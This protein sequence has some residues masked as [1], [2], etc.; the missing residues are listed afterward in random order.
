MSQGYETEIGE[1][2]KLV[3]LDERFLTWGVDTC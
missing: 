1:P 3:C 2:R